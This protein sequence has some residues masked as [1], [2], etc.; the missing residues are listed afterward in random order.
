MLNLMIRIDPEPHMI[1]KEKG[2]GEYDSKSG[3]KILWEG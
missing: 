3:C 1:I 2:S